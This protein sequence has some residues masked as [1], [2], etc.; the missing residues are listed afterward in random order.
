MTYQILIG[1]DCDPDRLGFSSS[2]KTN[3]LTWDGIEQGINSFRKQRKDFFNQHGILINVTWYVRS[4][5][6]IKSFFGE[7]GYCLSKFDA[8]WKELQDEGDEIS[9][10]PHVWD[11]D[12]NKDVWFQNSESEEFIRNC[13][14]EGFH[15]FEKNWGSKPTTMHAGWCFQNNITLTALSELG[16]EVDSSCLP[17]HNSFEKFSP[18][19][20][21][22]SQSP[23]EPYWP[24]KSNYQMASISLEGSFNIL[25]VPSSM[26]SSLSINILKSLKKRMSRRS[27]FVNIPEVKTQV[28]LICLNPKLNKGLLEDALN[29]SLFF[30]KPYF[31]SY[32]H[33]D[34]LLPGNMKSFM[35]RNLYSGDYFFKNILYLKNYLEIRGISYQSTTLKEFSKDIIKQRNEI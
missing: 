35:N 27:L 10:H 3:K 21:N 18:D 2:A 33:C 4:D 14:G 17:G 7:A 6:Q 25:E 24:S 22:W 34:E 15:S 20:S 5:L 12:H 26:G 19:S 8:L 23:N 29:K 30:H 1:C 9:W 31:S 11:Y 32:F 16:I 28:P 13:L